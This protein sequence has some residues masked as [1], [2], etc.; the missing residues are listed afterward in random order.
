MLLK[1]TTF[2][3]YICLR[4]VFVFIFVLHCK[5]STKYNLKKINM[6]LHKTN[7]FQYRLWDRS[8][9]EKLIDTISQNIQI[10]SKQKII[11]I[12]GYEK[13][14]ELGIKTTKNLIIVSKGKYLLT[15]FLCLIYGS[16]FNLKILM[17]I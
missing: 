12:I 10:I 5:S 9:D 8:I 13:L 3:V 1:Y 16:I 15:I 14:R 2:R 11:N 7:H 6:K 4:E 17:I